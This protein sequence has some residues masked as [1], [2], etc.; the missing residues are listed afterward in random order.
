MV[1]GP[2]SESDAQQY[3]HPGWEMVVVLCGRLD[4]FVGFGRYEL[5]PGDSL[6]FPSSRPHRY[7]NPTDATT[8]AIT[9]ILPD[10]RFADV[11]PDN[12]ST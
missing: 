4:I 2:R 6:S 10:V 7:V 5:G 3:R 9:V 12:G 11:S 8:R 1:Y